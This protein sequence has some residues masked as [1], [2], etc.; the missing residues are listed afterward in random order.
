[1]KTYIIGFFATIVPMLLLDIVWLTTM[2]KTF[3]TKHLG[4][5]FADKP[6]LTPALIFY[7]LYGVGVL[8]FVVMPLLR[9][10]ASLGTV[11]LTGAFLGLIAYGTYDLTNQATL[12]NWPTIVTVVDLMWG[13]FLTGTASTIAVWIMKIMKL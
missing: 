9:A 7:V 4:E 1:M 11:F 13:A 10:N 6:S 5:L 8:Y 12:K 3:Y 2:I